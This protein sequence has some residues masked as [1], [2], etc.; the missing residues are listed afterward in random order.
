MK[1]SDGCL[2]DP[3]DA[4]IQGAQCKECPRSSAVFLQEPALSCVLQ[5][6]AKGGCLDLKFLFLIPKCDT[7]TTWLLEPLG[8]KMLGLGWV[9]GFVSSLSIVCDI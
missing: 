1:G 3:V 7:K 6:W 4:L 9:L 5:L 8:H 2:G